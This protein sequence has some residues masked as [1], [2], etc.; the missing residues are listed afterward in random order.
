MGYPFLQRQILDP[1]KQRE[2]TDDNFKFHGKDR[3][4]SKRVENTVGEKGEIAFYE[5]FLLF[6]HC[7][8]KDMFYRYVKTRVCLGN[9]WYENL[10]LCWE[11]NGEKTQVQ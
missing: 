10:I 8:L 6:P 9:G 3:K 7:F 4:F 2:C 1:S 5:Q 11:E